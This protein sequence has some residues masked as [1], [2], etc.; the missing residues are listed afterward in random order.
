[1]RKLIQWFNNKPR[2]YI[3]WPLLPLLVILVPFIYLGCLV[4][5]AIEKHADMEVKYEV[6]L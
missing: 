5:D 4:A 2:P 1:M 6:H 3:V